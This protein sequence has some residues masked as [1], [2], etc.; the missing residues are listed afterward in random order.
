[1]Q[2]MRERIEKEKSIH[3]NGLTTFNIVVPQALSVEYKEYIISSVAENEFAASYWVKFPFGKEPKKKIKML[4]KCF[5]IERG[6]TDFISNP[7]Y[8]YVLVLSALTPKLQKMGKF[9]YVGFMQVTSGGIDFAWLHPFLRNKGI[10]STFLFNY[11]L[12]DYPLLLNPPVSKPMQ[13]CLKKVEDRIK[14]DK[15]LMDQ[16]REVQSRFFNEIYPNIGINKENVEKIAQAREWIGTL[17]D[18]D[19]KDEEKTKKMMEMCVKTHEYLESVPNR[20]E[21][22]LEMQQYLLSKS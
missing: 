15:N 11:S 1:M 2:N 4:K 13:G 3:K 9:F 5:E 20:E 18:F 22:I 6:D 8:Y 10:F 7:D 17:E 16:Y 14:S 12:N 19:I 21:I